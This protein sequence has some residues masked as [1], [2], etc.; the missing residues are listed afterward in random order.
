MTVVLGCES[1]PDFNTKKVWIPSM[2]NSQRKPSTYV[3]GFAPT[4]QPQASRECG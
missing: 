1:L 3:R 4:R 2:V